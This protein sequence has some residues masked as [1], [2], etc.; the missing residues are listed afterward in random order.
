MILCFQNYVSL[1]YLVYNCGL[2]LD[3]SV[4]LWIALKKTVK[5]RLLNSIPEKDLYKNSISN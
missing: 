2:Y 1:L 5:L 3:S 4:L